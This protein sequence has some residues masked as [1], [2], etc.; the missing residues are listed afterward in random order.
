MGNKIVR[1]ILVDD[2]REALAESKTQVKTQKEEIEILRYN[3]W[4]CRKNAYQAFMA[5]AGVLPNGYE[6]QM[7]AYEAHEAKKAKAK[8]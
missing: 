8:K 5:T 2:L 7:E 3:L 1:D 6:S 4:M